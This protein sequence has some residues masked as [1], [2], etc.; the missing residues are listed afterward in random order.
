MVS[1]GGGVELEICL[2][3]SFLMLRRGMWVF[4]SNEMYICHAFSM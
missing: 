3:S 1:L 4:N 2:A